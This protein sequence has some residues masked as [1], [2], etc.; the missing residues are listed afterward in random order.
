MKYK[1][2]ILFFLIAILSGCSSKKQDISDYRIVQPFKGDIIKKVLATGTLSPYRRIEIKATAQGR[3]EQIKVDEG[4][5]VRQG[6][7]LAFISTTDRISL[8]DAAKANLYEAKRKGDADLIKEAEIELSI[9]Q[10]A[11][12][13][14]PVIAPVSGEIIKRSIEVG[15][16]VTASQDMFVI[17]DRLVL[18]V[19]VDESDIGKIS[20]GQKLDFYLET[21]PDERYFGRVKRISKEGVEVNNVMQYEVICFPDKVMKKWIAGMTVNAEFVE[22]E[23]KGVLLLPVDA[24]KKISSQDDG[25]PPMPGM[26]D[27]SQ[28]IPN[29]KNMRFVVVL[30]NNKKQLKTVT[31]GISDYKNIEIAE[32]IGQDEQVLVLSQNDFMTIFKSQKG[33]VA[34][35]RKGGFRPGRIQRMMK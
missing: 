22:L 15:E 14:I 20:M 13:P 5:Y 17:S 10:K 3:V 19:Q 30:S 24:V 12:N 1:I 35:Q 11:Y 21:F 23:K 29:R 7:I 33:S 4:S 27:P 31:I 28:K 9:A 32:G 16:N 26:R 2:Y 34:K 6:Q 18:V 25:P 8:I